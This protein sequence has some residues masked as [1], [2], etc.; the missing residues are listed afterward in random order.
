MI[1][2]DLENSNRVLLVAVEI[3]TPFHIQSNDEMAIAGMRGFGFEDPVSDYIGI[4]C[5]RCFDHVGVEMNVEEIIAIV[6]LL[7]V[8]DAEIH[9]HF[10]G[11][12]ERDRR[13]EIAGEGFE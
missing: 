11:A 13:R 8:Y 4:G 10:A 9:G 2:A 1:D 3:R 6:L 5:H 7:L 12:A